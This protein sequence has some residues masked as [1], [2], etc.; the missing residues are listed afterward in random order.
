M[1]LNRSDVVEV[2]EERVQASAELVVPNLD[3]VVVAWR[4][5]V[6][7]E[8]GGWVGVSS[9]SVVCRC[10]SV[11]AVDRNAFQAA[12]ANSGGDDQIK[13]APDS[14]FALCADVGFFWERGWTPILGAD[15]VDASG[16]RS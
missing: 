5:W 2:P 1:E 7:G 6:W 16:I 11:M 15:R 10:G 4:G 14:L 3:L 9:A 12:A 8:G 13:S